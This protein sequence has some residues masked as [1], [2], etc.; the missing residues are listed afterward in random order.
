MMNYNW[1]SYSVFD[2]DGIYWDMLHSSS[3]FTYYNNA[4]LDK[5]YWKT[6]VDRLIRKRA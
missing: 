4:E 5:L 1:G 2:A 6:A 3:I